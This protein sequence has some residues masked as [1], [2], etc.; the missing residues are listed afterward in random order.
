VTPND[1]VIF[2]SR[3]I[4]GNEKGV[5]RI[6]NMLARRGARFLEDERSVHVSGHAYRDEQQLM[7]ECLRPKIFVPVH[8]EHRFLKRHAELAR[9]LGVKEAHVLDTGDTQSG[10][11]STARRLALS[12]A[13]RCGSAGV[14]RAAA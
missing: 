5:S 12:M 7:I 10:L 13:R 2:S 14:W 9:T 1:L 8:G 6:R 4:P 11:Q 3:V